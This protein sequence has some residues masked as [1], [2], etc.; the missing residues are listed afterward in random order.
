[1]GERSWK[2]DLSFPDL[3]AVT[4]TG[5]SRAGV[6]GGAWPE[7]TFALIWELWLN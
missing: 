6:E 3:E 7:K 4:L 1:M 2:S 5:P